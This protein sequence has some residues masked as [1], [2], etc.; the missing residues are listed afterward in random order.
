MLHRVVDISEEYWQFGG[1]YH[2]YHQGDKN[3]Q[4]RNNVSRN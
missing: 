2:S 3:L 1:T 4:A